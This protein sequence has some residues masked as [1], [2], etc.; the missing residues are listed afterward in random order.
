[1]SSKPGYVYFL[2]AR[3]TNRYKIGLTIDLDRR[4]KELNGSQAAQPI[5]M[6]WSIRVGNMRSA[7]KSLHDRFSANQVHGE[8]FEFQQSD[9]NIIKEAYGQVA[10]WYPYETPK[11]KKRPSVEAD[12]IFLPSPYS[13][14]N[15]ASSL[16]VGTI[17]VLGA[18]MLFSM[19]STPKQAPIGEREPAEFEAVPATNT[20]IS[21]NYLTA[22]R[23]ANIRQR[24]NGKIICQVEA[25]Q[26][27]SIIERSEWS[28]V[29]A[30]GTI[31]VIH[32]SVAR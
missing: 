25:G 23:L 8:W 6:L 22:T 3:G 12:D 30:C 29:Q 16:I 1:M 4:L 18:A 32:K 10:G 20:A 26:K 14:D 27:L 31:G 7:E 13:G 9:L 19:C 24:P 5:D 11:P 2:N 15:Y 28:K 21:Q 17:M